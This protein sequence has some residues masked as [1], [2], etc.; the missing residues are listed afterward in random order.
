MEEYKQLLIAYPE[1]GEDPFTYTKADKPYLLYLSNR[2]QNCT[3]LGEYELLNTIDRCMRGEINLPPELNGGYTVLF[4]YER[5]FLLHVG[6]SDYAHNGE[7]D[8]ELLYCQEG[9]GE[10]ECV[11]DKFLFACKDSSG[12]CIKDGT[13][14]CNEKQIR[15]FLGKD[16]YSIA[17]ARKVIKH[18]RE[19]PEYIYACIGVKTLESFSWH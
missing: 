13:W 12:I 4:H 15:E 1:N 9:L 3:H 10:N 16:K 8:G 18:I 5:M 19:N 11:A 2:K 14:R 7:C 6:D 17:D